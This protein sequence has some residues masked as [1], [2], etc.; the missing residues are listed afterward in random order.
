MGVVILLN[1][2][3]ERVFAFWY[4]RKYDDVSRYATQETSNNAHLSGA[5]GYHIPQLRYSFWNMLL[6]DVLV[7][8]SL[9]VSFR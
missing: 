7:S 3:M 8:R 4:Y 2:M 9:K 6:L 5:T 1:V